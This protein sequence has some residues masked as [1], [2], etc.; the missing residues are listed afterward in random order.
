MTVR[1]IGESSAVN[2][3]AYTSSL[4]LASSL[5]HG[6]SV[7]NWVTTNGD[8]GFVPGTEATYSPVTTDA[9]AETIVGSFPEV[10]L[11]EGE[12]LVLTGSI[13]ITG[14][15]GTINGNQIRWGMFDAPGTPA[16]GVGS[17]YVG[18]WAT[19]ANTGAGTIRTADGSTTNPFSGSASTV[20]ATENGTGSMTYGTEYDFVL[21]ITRFDVTQISVSG[22]L[23]DAGGASIN[24]WGETLSPASPAN[25]TYDSVAILIGGTTAAS[26]AAFSN[27][28]VSLV[29]EPSSLLLTFAG[30][31]PLLVRRRSNR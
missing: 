30:L 25:F 8:A 16:T 18:V 28:D 4:I 21:S 3:K 11:S 23:T 31:A 6:A 17:G 22:S 24:S 29:P 13:N 5:S 1:S 12:I 19:T 15:T 20:V 9:N 2:L 14:N 7:I 26:Q 10:T 27:V